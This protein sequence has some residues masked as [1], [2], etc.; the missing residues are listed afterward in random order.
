[1]WGANS[2][3]SIG[4]ACCCAAA[5]G[6]LL[7][8]AAQPAGDVLALPLL[9]PGAPPKPPCV[10]FGS[11]AVP[12]YSYGWGAVSRLLAVWGPDV[13]TAAYSWQVHSMLSIAAAE[14]AAL[15]LRHMPSCMCS[16]PPACC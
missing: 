11:M 1:V 4:A 15:G 14:L 5:G 7:G 10:A 13:N 6:Q 12:V 2:L 3:M 8:L 16:G 9:Q